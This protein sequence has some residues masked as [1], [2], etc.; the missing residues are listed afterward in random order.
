M[1]VVE[2][3]RPFLLSSV[4]GAVL[5]LLSRAGPSLP[6]PLLKASF[7]S[8]VHFTA[9]PALVGW[10]LTFSKRNY[11]YSGQASGTVSIS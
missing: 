10:T 4:G 7:T 11:A 1:D 9:P 2:K 3:R 5:S 8:N 6:H